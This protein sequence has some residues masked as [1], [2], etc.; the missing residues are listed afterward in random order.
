MIKLSVI[1]PV[2]NV[3]EYLRECL[4]SLVEQTL[5]DMEVLIVNDGSK[6]NSQAI[7]KEYVSKYPNKFVAFEKENGGLGDARNYAISY[8]KRRIYYFLR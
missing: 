8:C 3:E 4:D 7:I 5:T 1:V 2:Y 6:D